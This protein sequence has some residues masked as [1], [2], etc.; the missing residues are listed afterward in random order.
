MCASR[1]RAGAG[2]GQACRASCDA[3]FAR[4]RTKPLAAANLAIEKLRHLFRLAFTLKCVDERR[5]EHAARSLDEIGH[6]IG[7]WKKSSA[8]HDARGVSGDGEEV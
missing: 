7:A 6:L 2:K 1:T 5:Y 3:P 4:D 8:A